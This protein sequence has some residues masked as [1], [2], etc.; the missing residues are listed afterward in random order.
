MIQ[1]RF[2][3]LDWTYLETNGFEESSEISF[4]AQNFLLHQEERLCCLRF[5]RSVL[6]FGI[7]IS[8]SMDFF[9]FFLFTK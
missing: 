9:F 4:A 2:I 7:W 3:T 6:G 8:V 1:T 5:R